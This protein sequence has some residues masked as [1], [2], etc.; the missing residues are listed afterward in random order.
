MKKERKNCFP[1]AF[2]SLIR[3]FEISSR[4]YSRSEMK[5]KTCFPFAFLSLIR[6][7]ADANE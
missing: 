2:L 6:I 5:R 4:T 1:F 3:I 7:F